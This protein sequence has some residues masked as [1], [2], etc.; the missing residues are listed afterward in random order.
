MLGAPVAPRRAGTDAFA[1]VALRGC[2]CSC[3]CCS[4]ARAF[5]CCGGSAIVSSAEGACAVGSRCWWR[6]FCARG[7]RASS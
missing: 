2:G 7:G 1:I 3:G 4:A 6:G 5:G